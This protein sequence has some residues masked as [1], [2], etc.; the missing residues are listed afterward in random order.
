MESTSGHY[1]ALE[2]ATYFILKARDSK[3]GKPLTNMKLQKML[4]YAQTLYF[5]AR[6]Q[7]LF[8]EELI[9]VE[10]GAVI[11]SVNKRYSSFNHHEIDV[12]PEISVEHIKREDRRYLD[13]VWRIM[14]SF[15]TRELE[16]MIRKQKPWE[17]A[18][19]KEGEQTIDLLA[20]QSHF[21]KG[22]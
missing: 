3:D 1:S 22:A 15:A 19:T 11:P 20:V 8:H 13:D 2:I 4:Y 10:S 12:E 17:E 6:E 7:R 18:M 16:R 5:S 21:H 9:A 14:R